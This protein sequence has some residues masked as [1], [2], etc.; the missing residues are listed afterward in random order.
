MR[1][2]CGSMCGVCVWG[3]FAVCEACVR[4]ERVRY[5]RVRRV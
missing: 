2:V 3:M 5:E 1:Y 4:Y